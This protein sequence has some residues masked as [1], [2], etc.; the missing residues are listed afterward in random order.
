MLPAQSPSPP[1]SDV[2]RGNGWDVGSVH[3]ANDTASNSPAHVGRAFEDIM[4]PSLTQRACERSEPQ[5]T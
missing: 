5:T 1:G 4:M 2:G 3:P